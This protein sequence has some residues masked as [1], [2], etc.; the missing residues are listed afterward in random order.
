VSEFSRDTGFCSSFLDAVVYAWQDESLRQSLRA[1]RII[2]SV[3][4]LQFVVGVLRMKVDSTLTRMP[5]WGS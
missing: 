1:A 4:P 2:T 3:I 5:E